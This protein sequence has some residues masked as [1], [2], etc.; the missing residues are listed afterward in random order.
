MEN[1]GMGK[2]YEGGYRPFVF[3]FEHTPIGAISYGP[4]HK[5]VCSF[6][7]YRTSDNRMKYYCDLR[8]NSYNVKKNTYSN[9]KK[10]ITIPPKCLLAVIN[11]VTTIPAEPP[12]DLPPT[13]NRVI[14][15]VQKNKVVKICIS[16]TGIEGE[17]KLDIRENV[18]DVVHAFSGL[19]YKGVRIG[20]HMI[21]Q[22]TNMLQNCYNLFLDA[23]WKEPS[24]P[25]TPT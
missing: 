15:Q 23:G 8:M 4:S 17:P 13:G 16:L 5:L 14:A 9:S 6:V 3:K 21:G 11:A 20:Y 1:V 2:A 10:G 24:A 25:V 18:E 7:R 19:T 12:T 22:V